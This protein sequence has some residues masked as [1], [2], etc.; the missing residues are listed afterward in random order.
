MNLEA[1][2]LLF[3]GRNSLIYLQEDGGDGT[4]VVIKVLKEDYPSVEQITQFNNE[5]ELTKDLQIDGLRQARE[6]LMIGDKHALV[7]QYFDGEPAMQVFDRNQ[8]S[9]EE[10]LVVAIRIADTLGQLHQNQIIHKDINP[11][12]IL[13][14]ASSRAIKIIDLGIS[15]RASV[16]AAGSGYS[17]KLE[18]TLA[19]ISPEQTGRVNR[20]VDYATDLYSLGVTYYELLTGR[21]PF[22]TSDPLELVH[23]HIARKPTR[24]DQIDPAIPSVL[25][26]IVDRLLAKSAEDRYLSA[27]GLRSD[28]QRCLDAFAESGE[29]PSFTPGQHDVSSRFQI[30]PR[31]HGREREVQTLL[32]TFDRVRHD[33]EVEL[34]LV[35]G[36]S[37]V[38]KTSLVNE[39]QKPIIARRGHF[40]SGKFAQ[41]RRDIPYSALVEAFGGFV[42]QLMAESADQLARWRERILAA[43]GSNAGV[44]IQV[45]PTLELVLG[46]QPAVPE[47]GIAESQNRFKYAFTQFFRAIARNDHPLVLFIDDLQWA[48]LPSLNLLSH[49]VSE[50]GVADAMIIGAYRDNE[51]DP[52]HPFIVAMKKAEKDG[53]VIQEI[54][55]AP[56]AVDNVVALVSDTLHLE[57]A[58]VR[59]LAAL[60]HEKTGGNA[61][62]AGQF[63]ASLHDEELLT[64]DHERNRWS[65][66]IGDI[67]AKNTT[68]N[69]VAFIAGKIEKLSRETREVLSY[70]ACIGNRFT[71]G[72]LALIDERKQSESL[73]RLWQA[74]TEG[75]V[76]PLDD[77]YRLVS[78]SEERDGAIDTSWFRF[79]HDRVEQACYSRIPFDTREQLHLQIGR[80][81]RQNTNPGDDSSLFD[82]VNQLNRCVDLIDDRAERLQLAELNLAAGLEAR[83]ST[84]YDP[85][86][87]YLAV[88]TSL[89]PDDAWDTHYEL[90][91]DLY[92]E[93]IQSE[94]LTANFAES[95]RLADL[96]LSNLRTDVDKGD[97]YHRLV[98]QHAMEGDYARAL[99][100]M[101]R[102]LGLLTGFP[103][104]ADLAEAIAVHRREIVEAMAGRTVASLADEPQMTDP[105]HLVSMDLLAAGCA[106]AYLSDQ[107]LL[108]WLGLRMVKLTLEHGLCR[109][110]AQGLIVHGTLLAGVW[111]DY[112]GAYEFGKL[113]VELAE[114]AG[115]DH[116]CRICHSFG[117]NILAWTRPIRESYPVYERGYQ[118]GLNSGEYQYAGYISFYRLA[119]PY[120][121]GD[122]LSGIYD[123]LPGYLHFTRKTQ[124]QVATDCIVGF[125]FLLSNLMGL[126]ADQSSFDLEDGSEQAFLEGSLE[127]QSFY[128]LCPF[129]LIKSQ[130]LYWYGRYEEALRCSEEAG[131]YIAFVTG[132]M[133]LARHAFH[134]SLILLALYPDAS[135]DEKAAYLARVAE[136]QAR[137]KIWAEQ[138]EAN[139]LHKYLL[140]EAERARVVGDHDAPGEPVGD[141]VDLYD[142]AI[143]LAREHGFTQDQATAK[144]RAG[145]YW[146]QRG[147]ED[148]ALIY[149][150]RARYLFETW[151]ATRVAEHLDARYG[152][153]RLRPVESNPPATGTISGTSTY[154]VSTTRAA[155]GLDISSIMKAAQVLSQEVQLDA[156]LEKMLTILCESAGAD[157]AV[158]IQNLGD[159]LVVQAMRDEH[160]GRSVLLEAQPLE[161]NRDLPH[162]VINYVGRLETPLVINDVA[163]D[164]FADDPYFQTERP[165]SVLCFPVMAQGDLR[166][167]LYFE[168]RLSKDAFTA[169]RIELL[170][171]L[172]A[173]VAISLDNANLYHSLEAKVVE[174]TRQLE[175]AQ[176][177]IVVLE[178]EAT[179]RRMAGGFAHEMRNALSASKMALA[180]AFQDGS[181]MP[182]RS[183]EHL[184][185]LLAERDS[186]LQRA[187]LANYARTLEKDSRRLDRALTIARD[188]TNRALE[189]TEQILDY[190]RLG[191]ASAGRHP[192]S[193]R[194]VIDKII[195]E[196]QLRT[197]GLNARITMTGVGDGI[198]E[199]DESHL[200]SIFKNLIDNAHDALAALE[201]DRERVIEIAMSQDSGELTVEI[202]DNGIGIP[203]EDQHKLFEPFFSRKP[204]TGT[205]LGLSFVSKLLSIYHGRI[206]MSSQPGSE[207]TFRVTLPNKLRRRAHSRDFSSKR[208][209]GT[210]AE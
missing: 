97:V 43:V 207:T 172:S 181:S 113:A 47:L 127:R 187:R 162:S 157:R 6:R 196:S 197:Q 136:N 36:Y 32:E 179:E 160:S 72:T 114:Q 195:A 164:R 24:I 12:N 59:D 5:Y 44:L 14:D 4:P 178:K 16:K 134:H 69:V 19:Y 50:D 208:E 9:L 92:R 33:G 203:G 108:M 49:L 1:L 161:G 58:E 131:K 2:D 115:P 76:V 143:V 112:R 56:L 144:V 20:S 133:P 28:L 192:V 135:D 84:A 149:L 88:G 22:D 154:L 61:F 99:D 139:F 87:T 158:V 128:G 202:R 166:A 15:S 180:V 147:K 118:A 79:L 106:P 39:V 193:V 18:G 93:R 186:D 27:H 29:I 153:A 53:A 111:Q 200:Y 8:R 73:A 57:R 67:R 107:E 210:R 209:I 140:V 60:I 42:D 150:R 130:I 21:L 51:V 17:A 120:Y 122:P 40:I 132:K 176:E 205:G 156:L 80:V 7:L 103:A 46:E 117:S 35:A 82:V 25:A 109:Q 34:V 165:R 155:G 125:R 171:M 184:A 137:M 68:D 175:R 173:Q 31:L 199:G 152:A 23:C 116:L 123:D 91:R 26:D 52:S 188:A 48:G 194:A 63:L 83:A 206:A 104:R 89:L 41:F 13:V 3:E 167:V 141:P 198:V 110:T 159:I 101:A 102:G 62:F 185:E 77:N 90:T 54:H 95:E 169:E 45:I 11:S 94:Y 37:G 183:Y 30:S 138:C 64:F 204:A 70:A 191:Y 81:L 163:A 182:A 78:A 170:R 65:W 119:M 129:Y 66:T 74:I 38:G 190:S 148:F 85:A 55:L 105:V 124:N 98:I 201:H 151:G 126:T 121:Q 75:M 174:R 177:Q 71:L 86:R 146:L 145:A 189:V 168:N 100:V 96:T 10:F 142:R